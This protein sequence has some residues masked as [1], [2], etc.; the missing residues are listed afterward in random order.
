[1]ISRR[2]GQIP[3]GRSTA[4]GRKKVT[5]LSERFHDR[6]AHQA[7]TDRCRSSHTAYICVRPRELLA[8]DDSTHRKQSIRER[9]QAIACLVC[10][11]FYDARLCTPRLFD[12]AQDN[13][14]ARTRL[15]FSQIGQRSNRQ[16]HAER[17]FWTAPGTKIG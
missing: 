3:S 14:C 17:R 2:K 16:V 1:M 12:C 9:T 8:T 11:G 6:S 5:Q 10:G 4:I 7:H 13:A 15:D